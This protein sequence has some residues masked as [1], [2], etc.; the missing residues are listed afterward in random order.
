MSRKC[1]AA[2]GLRLPLFVVYELAPRV[3]PV[4]RLPV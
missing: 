2:D 3:G 1:V 4:G